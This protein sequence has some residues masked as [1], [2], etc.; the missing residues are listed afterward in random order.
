MTTNSSRNNFVVLMADDDPDDVDLMACALA[1]SSFPSEFRSVRDGYE[2]IQYLHRLGEY[3]D[4]PAK[5]D[6][7]HLPA[8]LSPYVDPAPNPS[9]I[10]LDLNMPRCNG[11]EVLAELKRTPHLSKIP[12]VILTT[13]D[14]ERDRSR[15]SLLG[16]SGFITKPDD[17]SRLIEV[18]RSLQ[19]FRASVWT[20]ERA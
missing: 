14:A 8:R 16:A 20:D 6:E 7:D 13:S 12:V 5:P 4:A 18:T 3:A 10:L 2:L 11:I 15:T 19:S 9:L 1:Q 17:F